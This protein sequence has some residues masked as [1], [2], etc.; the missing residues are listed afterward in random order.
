MQRAF[1][2]AVKSLRSHI[3]GKDVLVFGTL[4]D[5]FVEVV[6]LAMGG[7][8]RV[9]SVDQTPYRTTD[10]RIVSLTPREFWRCVGRR[11]RQCPAYVPE[12]FHIPRTFHVVVAYSVV[13]HDGLGRY[14]DALDAF[15]D[16]KLMWE[17][18]SLLAPGPS[19]LLLLGVPLGNDCVVFNRHRVYGR[20]RLPLLLLGYEVYQAHGF[21]LEVS[22]YALG[23]TFGQ[24]WAH[25]NRCLGGSQRIPLLVLQ[26]S[27]TD[28]SPTDVPGSSARRLP[29]AATRSWFRVP[30]LAGPYPLHT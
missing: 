24:S 13:Q 8:R 6:M 10:A 17:L 11:Q 26:K 20:R 18:R 19:S 28:L 3:E 21:D 9:V 25:D 15:G 4:M 23:M 14:G 7:A 29:A 12:L 1:V 16:V 2:V 27:A 22:D 5:P 30:G